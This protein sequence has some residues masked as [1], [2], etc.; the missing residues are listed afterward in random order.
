MKNIVLIGDGMADWPI[1]S[2]GDRTPLEA[3][4]T[5][6][7]DFLAENG[8]LVEVHTVPEGMPPGSDV[9]ILSI[10]GYD[11]NKWYTGRA[12]LEAAS[13]GLDVPESA[14][15]FRCN[16]VTVQNGSMV[17]YAADHI[18]TTE[19]TELIHSVDETLSTSQLKFYPGISYR[20]LMVIEGDYPELQCTPPHDILGKPID[21]YLPQGNGQEIIRELMEK[22]V[23]L[24]KKHP[25][26]IKRQSEGHLPATQ[27]WLWGQ[28]K[29]PQLESFKNMFQMDTGI[30]ISAVDLV[31]G[32]GK[33]AKLTVPDIPG[34]T[35]Y[36]DTD[37]EAKVSAALEGLKQYEFA[38]IHVEAPDECGHQGRPDLKIRAIEEFDEKVIGPMLE[39]AR[40]HGECR[41]MVLPD[42]PTPCAIRTHAAEPIPAVM[43]EFSDISKKSLCSGKRFTEKNARQSEHK[44]KHGHELMGYFLKGNW[45]S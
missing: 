3:A 4:S 6:N 13:M 29:M 22:S 14:S 33:L 20:H 23:S 40:S 17:D 37:Y 30:I 41:L 5:P 34:L 10:M 42:H 16:T 1:P 19:S 31:K 25:V 45:K 15:V 2:L 44:I 39:Y 18:T 38:L 28:G 32:I 11:P 7:L 35:G 26:N 27:I 12:P 8:H 43:I 21:S 9:A 36:L 24:W